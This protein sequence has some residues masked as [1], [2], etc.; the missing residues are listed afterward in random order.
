[1][2]NK[3]T[4]AVIGVILMVAIT[5]AIAATVYVYVSGIIDVE[6][7]DWDMTRE[8]LLASK[9]YW[10]DDDYGKLE[11]GNITIYSVEQLGMLP[12]T[13]KNESLIGSTI[14]CF[15]IEDQADYKYFFKHASE[16][17]GWNTT[18][19]REYQ[20]FKDYKDEFIGWELSVN[21]PDNF[22]FYLDE[23]GMHKYQK[24]TKQVTIT[25]PTSQSTV[26][27]STI[28]HYRARIK[29]IMNNP[30]DKNKY[31]SMKVGEHDK[32]KYEYFSTILELEPK[33]SIS[34]NITLE[35]YGSG[36]EQVFFPKTY[37]IRMR[38]ELSYPEYSYTHWREYGRIERLNDIEIPII[39]EVRE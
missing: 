27:N 26:F 25:N 24:V 15:Y 34:F 11:Q 6:P 3:A 10:K 9:D 23:H 29:S 5:V 37:T 7:I 32:G 31:F 33:Q 18:I 35:I 21:T 36:L 8:E 38:I 14:N 17:I 19:I 4:S 16:V 1:M 12:C 20:K 22:T 39:F 30:L 28:N 2:N 13:E